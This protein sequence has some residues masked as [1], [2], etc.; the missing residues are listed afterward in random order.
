MVVKEKISHTLLAIV[1]LVISIPNIFIE[2]MLIDD[3][4]NIKFITQ[5]NQK[6]FSLQIV[7]FIE[8]LLEANGRFRPVY[9]IY[10]W[11][12]YLFAGKNFIAMRV[13]HVLIFALITYLIYKF[14]R[15]LTQSDLVALSGSLLFLL[16]PLNTENLLR[17]GPQEPL[18]AVFSL[19]AI[20]LLIFS[21]R[22]YK[23]SAVFVFLALYSKESAIALL[24]SVFVIFLLR[25]SIF[26]R[27][28]KKLYT[29]KLLIFSALSSLA[30][31]LI[32]Q[33]IRG[34]YSTNYSVNF[35][36]IFENVAFYLDK[37][38]LYLDVF[39]PLAAWGLLAD[40]Y[41]FFKNKSLTKKQ[42]I[43]FISLTTFF[44]FFVIQLPWKYAL[45]RYLLPASAFLIVFL[46]ME[47]HTF[48]EFV[49]SR[50]SKKW[51]L[52]VYLF[53]AAYLFYFVFLNLLSVFNRTRDH[54][55][56]TMAITDTMK[57]LAEHTS[58]N[59][60]VYLDLEKGEHT[61]EYVVEV[62]L[63][64]S[65]FYA[66]GDVEVY[67]LEKDDLA[68][69]GMV[70]SSDIAANKYGLEELK[71]VI[72][73]EP[74]EIKTSGEMIVLSTPLNIIKQTIKK[75]PSLLAGRWPGWEG[76]YTT[77]YKEHV[78]YVFEL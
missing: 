3:A 34:G 15:K 49:A 58:R 21:D 39:L 13:G 51:R 63:H 72:D 61:M 45:E 70:V 32:T 69:S 26:E 73:Q 67:Y 28:K 9:W 1:L 60:E 2:W 64:L 54:H 56:Y 33:S 14:V 25:N 65:E 18:V 29:R 68:S 55:L 31:F 71:E 24:G 16:T 7:P 52:A 74:V 48:L 57:Y 6:I 35:S 17:I 27:E 78:W 12:I 43:S 19:V 62:D 53:F 22:Y 46:S 41:K 59:G 10:Q 66:R 11:I 8:Q 23:Y 76:V 47:I 36:Q 30:L 40:L 37:L 75:V 38:V 50:V 20:Y 5:L 77:Y 42:H 44:F 4:Y